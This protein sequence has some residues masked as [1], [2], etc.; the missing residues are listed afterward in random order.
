MSDSDDI[1]T[2]ERSPS[3]DWGGDRYWATERCWT[4]VARIDTR[5]DH[6]TFRMILAYMT[7]APTGNPIRQEQENTPLENIYDS[8]Q[9]SD[10]FKKNLKKRT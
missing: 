7:A 1:R 3:G 8:A 10:N 4:A 9:P 5:R 6:G 2:S